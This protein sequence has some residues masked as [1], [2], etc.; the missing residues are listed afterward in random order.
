MS[1]LYE[2]THGKLT[3]LVIAYGIDDF[4]LIV[5]DNNSSTAIATKKF[6]NIASAFLHLH[7]DILKADVYGCPPCR[8]KIDRQIMRA[9]EKFNVVKERMGW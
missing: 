1:T 6:D 3:A 9:T 4:E 2:A 8:K 5:Y 7:K